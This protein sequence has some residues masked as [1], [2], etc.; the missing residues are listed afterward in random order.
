[1]QRPAAKAEA[2]LPRLADQEPTPPLEQG[3][4]ASPYLQEEVYSLDQGRPLFLFP[5]PE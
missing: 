2:G 1:M 5:F 3:A 4:L